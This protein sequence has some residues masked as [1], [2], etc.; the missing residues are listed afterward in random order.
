MANDKV[1]PDLIDYTAATAGTVAAGDTFCFSDVD[2][3]GN[4]KQ[5]TVQGL[6]DLVDADNITEGTEQ[7]TTSGTAFDYTSIP[8]GTKRI[9]ISFYETSTDGTDD[10]LVQ[11]GDSGGLETT[12]YDSSTASIRNGATSNVFSSTSGFICHDDS[13]GTG[14][15]LILTRTDTGGT[16]WVGSY[17]SYISSTKCSSGG[18]TK[19]LTA[20][21]DR[22][23]IT[24]TGTDT[25]DSGS[26]NITYE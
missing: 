25:F 18:G 19:T 1:N 16:K 4:T 24:R 6:L 26:V 14:G 13:A 12:G 15:H 11:I 9:V 17:S 20:E 2:D 22:L 5:D 7:A 8:S 10:F 3:S 23:R 21:L